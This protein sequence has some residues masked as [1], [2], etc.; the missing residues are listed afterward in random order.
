[1]RPA[2][3]ALLLGAA[4][5]LAAQPVIPCVGQ[6]I[7]SIDIETEAP[8]VTGLR[9]VPLAG[10]LV[11][12]THVVTRDDIIR[13]F[14]LLK[15]GDRCSEARRAESER[16]LRAQ[17]F[18]ADASVEVHPSTA[19]GVLLSVRTIDDVSMI[20][21]GSVAT[22]APNVRA[23]RLGSSNLAGIGITT[24]V[25]WKH[26]PAFDDYLQARVI[27]HQFAG[28]PYVLDLETTKHRF[29]HDDHAQVLLPF[30]TDFQRFAWRALIG[31]SRGHALF[32]ARDSSRVALGFAREFF[33]AGGIF[34]V[35]P[36]GR[37]SL[38]G[39]SLSN[40]RSQPDDGVVR[41]SEGGFLADTAALLGPR[42]SATRAARVNALLGLRGLRFRRMR[43]FDAM[44]GTQDIPLGL[45]LGTVVGRGISAFGATGSDLFVASDLYVAFGGPR[46]VVR[47]QLQGEGRRAMQSDAPW[48]ALV[49]SGRLGFQHRA[50]DRRTRAIS[51]EFSGTERSPIPHSLSLAASDGGVRG[52]SDADEFGGRRGVMRLEER[53]FLGSPFD[54]SDAGIALFVDGGQLWPGDIPYAARTPMRGSA[55]LSLLVAIP[56]RS[57]RT[58]RLDFAVPFN[59][60]K[61]G[62]TWEIRLRN[63]D[64]TTFFWREPADVNS[65]RARAVPSSVY[66]WP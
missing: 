27:D 17:P 61:G 23:A 35:G 10:K 41:V 66:S 34:R 57:T 24:S 12:R 48:N 56:M 20:L 30:R 63:S 5:S 19:G 2:V 28:Q 52:F 25:A 60:E 7:D 62:R 64:L 58:W 45:Q 4:S 13:R 53:L 8:S 43:G 33:D 65:A 16:I 55:G 54:Y 18:L 36:P 42:F 9:R 37:L 38:V 32:E 46:S 49:G 31:T 26:E 3:C 14:L 59:P 21:S 6:R 15:P 1:V 40:E 51:V 44:R 22:S 11:R 39:V 29:G 50:T 47:L